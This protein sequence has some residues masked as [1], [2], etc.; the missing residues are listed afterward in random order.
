M[1]T[2]STIQILRNTIGNPISRKIID[3][4]S[5]YCETCKKNRIDVALE[6]FNGVRKDAC[7]KCRLAEKALSGIIR[8]GGKT[9]GVNIN[10]IK[11]KFSDPSWL[12]AFSLVLRGIADFGIQKPF[13]TGAPFLIVWDITY[14]CNLKCKHCYANAGKK[15]ENELT[16]EEA[17]K[18][19]DILDKASVPVISFSGGEPLIRPD[20]F[21]LTRYAADKGIYVAVAT[22]GTLITKEKAKE[23]K[24]AGIQFTQIS[25]DGA[26]AKTHD[27]FR[28]IDGVFEKTIKGIKN[29]VDEGFFVNIATTAIKNNYQEIPK[30]IYLCEKMNVTWF[31]LYNFV[32]TGRGKFIKDNDLTSYER[33]KLLND[34]WFK[35]KDKSHKVNIL[36]TAPQFARIALQN[37]YCEINYR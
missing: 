17:K 37:G 1:E 19:I 7:I 31:M 16:T 18:V 29:A 26:T 6:I 28:G 36:S 27:T 33:E 13:I 11:E 24:K 9:F 30:I 35:L 21:E 20:I 14:A 10:Q 3:K 12:K 8:T 4:F 32:P 25:L 2:I 5:S 22:N 34:I 15:L 23:M